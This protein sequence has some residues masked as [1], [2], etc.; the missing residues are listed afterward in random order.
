[1]A[2]YRVVCMLAQNKRQRVVARTAPSRFDTETIAKAFA[3]HYD[4][5]M[6]ELG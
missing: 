2:A 1:M 5:P 4:C 6:V 3:S